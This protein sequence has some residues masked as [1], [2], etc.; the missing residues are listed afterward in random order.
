MSEIKFKIAAKTHVGMVR[1]NNEDNFQAVS[2]LCVKPMTWVQDKECSLNSKGALLVVADGMGGM[3]AGEVAS[4]IATNTMR[5]WFSPV[6][7][8]DEVVKSRYTIERFM[9]SAIVEADNRIKETAKARPETHGMGTTIVLGWV[10]GKHLYVAW[11][12][13]SRAYVYNPVYG[14]RQITKDHSYVQQL[15][16]QGKIA[17]EDAFDYPDSNIITRCLSDSPTKAH[18][19]CLVMPHELYDGDVILLCTDGLSG[20]LHDYEIE[21]VISSNYQNMEKC[22]DALIKG[23]CEAGGHDNVTVVLCKILSGGSVATAESIQQKV[24]LEEEA[25]RKEKVIRNLKKIGVFTGALFLVAVLLSGGMYL[26]KTIYSKS[27]SSEDNVCL[28]NLEEG[29]VDSLL[30]VYHEMVKKLTIENEAL[31][32]KDNKEIAEEGKNTINKNIPSSV[33]IESKQDKPEVN[34]TPIDNEKAKSEEQEEETENYVIKAGDTLLGIA[35]RI[36][37]SVDSIKK[38]NPQLENDDNIKEGETIIVP[39]KKDK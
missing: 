13:D 14:L 21:E 31:K 8:T 20:L 22:S 37:I 10:Y 4:E 18:P 2:D 7:I 9:K 11:C 39:K 1:D 36:E 34:I 28:K 12:G 3:N 27:K 16:D 19:D 33:G 15:V 32:A 6:N 25:E 5:D 24:V 26:G 30:K 17:P 38:L 29:P 23:A 35:K